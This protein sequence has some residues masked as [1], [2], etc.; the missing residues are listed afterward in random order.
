MHHEVLKLHEKYGP[1]VRLGP[2]EISFI[3]AAAWKDIYSL[4]RYKEIE[5]CHKSFPAITPN[6]A[7][8]DLLTPS[9]SDHAKYRKILNPSF[10]DKTTKEYEP[11]V[12]QNAN[13]MISKL[14]TGL[15]NGSSRINITK[16]FQWLTFDI[17]GDVIWGDPF[18]CIKEERNHPCLALSMDLVSLA[19]LI[20]LVA[21]WTSLKV[22]LIKLAG[23]EA[24][25]VNMVRSKCEMNRDSKS[26]KAN[27]FSNLT[28]E[29][30]LLNE[31]ELD[32]N[33]S[34]L[35]VAGSE[36]TGFTL[37]STS[38][39]LA[40]NPECFRKVAD[41]VRSAFTS[42]EEINDDTLK[43]LPYLRAT[44][45]EALRLNPAAPNGIVRRVVSEG[46][47]IRGYF[48]PKGASH[49]LYLS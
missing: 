45:E 1:V 47:G 20:V 44:I 11:A 32:G 24:K 14:L 26:E 5:R 19:S 17:V 38:F 48:I 34:G 29:G 42:E 21:W 35:V 9:A 8:F 41:E 10:S 33:L 12:H 2:S 18:D 31:P 13:N 7:Q 36:T 40:N 15:R 22:F 25:F 4:K 30:G 3:D 46:I 37:T 27:I 39:C 23:I 28:K 16:W 49:L 43:K 6:D